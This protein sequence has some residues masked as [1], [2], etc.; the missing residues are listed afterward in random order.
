[1]LI[2]YAEGKREG[3]IQIKLPSEVS[4]FIAELRIHEKNVWTIGVPIM[5]EFNFGYQHGSL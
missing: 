5:N 1:M 2:R 4:G 3:A